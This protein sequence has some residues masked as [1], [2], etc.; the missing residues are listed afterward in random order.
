MLSAV[1][2]SELLAELKRHLAQKREHFRA[3]LD[4]DEPGAARLRWSNYADNLRALERIADPETEIVLVEIEDS[5]FYEE[6]LVSTK[7]YAQLAVRVPN[8]LSGWLR[9]EGREYQ[10]TNHDAWYDQVTPGA[11]FRGSSRRDERWWE[12]TMVIDKR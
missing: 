2:K 12:R 1:D 9:F 5:E 8:P 10:L 11:T 7:T 4:D 3:E 6:Q